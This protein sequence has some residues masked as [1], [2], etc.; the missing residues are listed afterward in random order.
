MVF[1]FVC[2]SPFSS[3]VS[4][5]QS[6]ATF[7]AFFKEFQAEFD[8]LDTG[9]L[10]VLIRL[11]LVQEAVNVSALFEHTRAEILLLTRLHLAHHIE[12]NV[13]KTVRFEGPTVC[14][15]PGNGLHKVSDDFSRRD[16]LEDWA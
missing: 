4:S 13:L 5:K 6:L 12:G 7:K 9:V 10:L 14:I 15:L 3:L 11:R 1:F 2:A 8:M 16:Q